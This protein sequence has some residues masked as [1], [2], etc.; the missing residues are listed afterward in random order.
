MISQ[1]EQIIIGEYSSVAT[2]ESNVD[3]YL[4]AEG[5][6]IVEEIRIGRADVNFRR[7]ADHGLDAGIMDYDHTVPV[8]E[9]F[10]NTTYEAD[11]DD[12]AFSLD[13]PNLRALNILYSDGVGD[14]SVTAD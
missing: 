1:V 10:A 3:L 7:G 4:V 13:E 9:L 6:G 2:A 8:E 5:R 11:G 12:Y 14:P